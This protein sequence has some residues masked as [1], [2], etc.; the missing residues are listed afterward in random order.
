MPATPG[1]LAGESTVAALVS[2]R[3][4]HE[5]A[6]CRQLFDDVGVALSA[7]VVDPRLM[8]MMRAGLVLAGAP[9]TGMPAAHI[10]PARMSESNPP[11][12]PSTRTGKILDSR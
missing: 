5:H 4:H 1:Q 2:G 6:H 9:D 10:I 12:L 8:L 7:A 3:D 11:H